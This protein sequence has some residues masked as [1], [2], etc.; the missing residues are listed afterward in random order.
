MPRRL[1]NGKDAKRNRTV[2]SAEG[3]KAVKRLSS[4]CIC[5]NDKKTKKEGRRIREIRKRSLNR[6]MES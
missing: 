6:E 4:N 2:A 3:R 5:S 1:K